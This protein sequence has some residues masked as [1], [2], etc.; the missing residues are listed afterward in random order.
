MK[1]QFYYFFQ[2]MFLL[3]SIKYKHYK[4]LLILTHFSYQNIMYLNIKYFNYY[5]MFLKAIHCL[6]Y[7]EL[8]IHNNLYTQTILN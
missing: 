1:N 2:L 5:K 6:F 3:I 7:S 4:V 8:K